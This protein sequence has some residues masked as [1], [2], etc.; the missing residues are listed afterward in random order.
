MSTEK[1]FVIKSNDTYT[2]AKTGNVSNCAFYFKGVTLGMFVTWDDAK[3]AKKFKTKR[4]AWRTVRGLGRFN[5]PSI[6]VEEFQ[7]VMVQ[8]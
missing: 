8:S 2:N 6:E 1:Q 7:P 4:E 5:D 3:S